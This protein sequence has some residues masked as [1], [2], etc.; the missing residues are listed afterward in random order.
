MKYSFS[1]SL[2]EIIVFDGVL[3]WSWC[4]L[5]DGACD[6]KGG[7]YVENLELLGYRETNVLKIWKFSDMERLKINI[8]KI[9]NSCDMEKL[10]IDILQIWN[11]DM[12]RL[13]IDILK[14]WNCCDMERLRINILKI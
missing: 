3:L 1:G 6:G 5:S 10:P 2:E 13:R 12:E 9:W 8:L 11:C 7:W 4:W 14:T